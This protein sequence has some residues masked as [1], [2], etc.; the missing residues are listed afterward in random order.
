MSKKKVRD[1]FVSGGDTVVTEFRDQCD[2]SKVS[3][4]RRNKY[5]Y[6]SVMKK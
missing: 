1:S 3:F 6:T 4:I 5:L 2:R